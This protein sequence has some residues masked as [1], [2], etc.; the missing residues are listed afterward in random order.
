MY[1]LGMLFSISSYLPRTNSLHALCWISENNFS[2]L[3]CSEIDSSLETTARCHYNN[4]FIAP[5]YSYESKN[6]ARESSNHEDSNSSEA[7]SESHFPSITIKVISKKNIEI[8][9]NNY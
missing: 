1:P 3:K 9:L 4:S 6:N 5:H 2:F 7:S 8:D